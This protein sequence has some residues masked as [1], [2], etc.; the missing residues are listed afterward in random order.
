MRTPTLRGDSRQRHG[1]R[2]AA[3]SE[4]TAWP[5]LRMTRVARKLAE[6]LDANAAE[7]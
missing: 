4:H 5:V 3:G 1:G 2:L 6:A 7:G